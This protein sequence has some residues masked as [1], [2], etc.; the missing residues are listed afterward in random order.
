MERGTAQEFLKSIFG[1][2][3]ATT[4]SRRDILAGFG[5]AGLLLAAPKLLSPSP[6]EAK[7]LD[8]LAEAATG[9]LPAPEVTSAETPEA[10]ESDIT[11]LSSRRYWRR[12][13]WR[14]RYWRHRYWRRR[15][16]RRRYWRR[17]YW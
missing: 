12:R 6:A 16:W 7:P 5:L 14:R 11:D 4:P 17:R 2:E 3:E 15:Y 8:K 10:Q 13:Y 9:S 1:R